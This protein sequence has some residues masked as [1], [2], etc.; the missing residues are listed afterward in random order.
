MANL[1]AVDTRL[2]PF[3][4]LTRS[5]IAV[6][7]GALLTAAA[8]AWLRRGRPGPPL[9]GARTA[10]REVVRDPVTAVF[11]GLVLVLFA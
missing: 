9:A 1:G 3:Y 10:V 7:E 2:S 5:G 8:G 11:L 4:A 6:T